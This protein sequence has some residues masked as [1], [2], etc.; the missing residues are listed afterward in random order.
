MGLGFGLGMPDSIEELH[1]GRINT[2]NRNS[3]DDD[4][5]VLSRLVLGLRSVSMPGF[6][7]TIASRWVYIWTT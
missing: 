1:R 4:D 2:R 7:G 6:S 3:D 5:V